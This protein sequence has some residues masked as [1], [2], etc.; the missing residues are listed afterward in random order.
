MLN[1]L[2]GLGCS[3]G[4]RC[5]IFGFLVSKHS[6]IVVLGAHYLGTWV[7]RVVRVIAFHGCAVAQP[8]E[9]FTFA[10]HYEPQGCGMLRVL[11]KV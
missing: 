1:F 4:S 3:L 2:K 7:P 9:A 5:Q 11:V 10:S 6:H 8:L